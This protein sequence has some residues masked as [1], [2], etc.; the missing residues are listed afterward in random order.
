MVLTKVQV[1]TPE[2]LFR[3]PPLQTKSFANR[4]GREGR[5]IGCK[6]ER[7]SR[8]GRRPERE[9]AE[10]CLKRVSYAVC[11]N[12][13][14]YLPR[15]GGK[16]K[17]QNKGTKNKRGGKKQKE[18]VEQGRGEGGKEGRVSGVENLATKGPERKK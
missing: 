16:K 10:L 17:G 7:K 6:S 11:R 12:Q 3:G 2:F 13:L 15:R 18:P 5:D 14:G 8:R 4:E 1:K 9:D